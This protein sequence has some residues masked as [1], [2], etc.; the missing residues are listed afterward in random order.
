MS[1]RKRQ[2][3][4]NIAAYFRRDKHPRCSAE[5]EPGPSSRF[6]QCLASSYIIIS[7]GQYRLTS[8]ETTTEEN[9]SEETTTEEITS[10]SETASTM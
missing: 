3:Y 1:S 2:A 9:T 7:T 6:A 5:S 4:G 10:E 8:E